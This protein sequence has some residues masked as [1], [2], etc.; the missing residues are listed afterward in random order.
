[1]AIYLKMG[2]YML[3][4]FAYTI[5]MGMFL[6]GELSLCFISNRRKK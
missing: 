2:I 1:M 6:T 5:Y 3:C 4:L